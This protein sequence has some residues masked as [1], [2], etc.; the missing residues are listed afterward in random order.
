MKIE[1]N[2]YEIFNNI[3]VE[4]SKAFAI[5]NNFVLF[6][7]GYDEEGKIHLYSMKNNCLQSF[8]LLN[9]N[10]DILNYDDSVGVNSSLKRIK[11]YI[12]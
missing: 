12:C 3:P 1:K 10:G 11:I 6:N 7:N 8:N 2:D 9:L 4:G 5:M